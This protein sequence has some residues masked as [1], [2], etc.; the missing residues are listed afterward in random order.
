MFPISYGMKI[1]V[2]SISLDRKLFD[3]KSATRQRTL[4]YGKLADELHVIVFN[5]SSRD[6]FIG[7]EAG[8]DYF[9]IS[10][11]VYVYPTNSKSR[12]FYVFDAL[13][14]AKEIIKNRWQN[15]TK[16]CIIT[17][18]D[19]FE[20][21]WIALRIKKK[22]KLRL[23]VQIHT[24]IFSPFFKKESVLNQI[25]FWM[26]KSVVFGADSIRVV[27]RRVKRALNES[28]AVPKEKIYVLPIYVD[29]EKIRQTPVSVNLHEKYPQ[30]NFICLMA[31]RWTKEKNIPLAINAF[32]KV[33]KEYPGAGLVIVG[34][35][36]EEKK[37]LRKIRWF[38]LTK[39]IVMEGWSDDLISYYKSAD[40]F[41]L[42]SNYEGYGMSVVEAMAAGC[43]V[44]MTGVGLAG[45]LL[46]HGYN[47]L[48]VPPRR[49]EMLAEMILAVLKDPQSAKEL[50]ANA[51]EIIRTLP[52]KEEYLKKYQMIW[53]A[54]FGLYSSADN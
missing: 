18:Q 29:A 53:M 45:D 3:E 34:K 42:T 48:A 26:A 22:F 21:G 25:R 20:S 31:S 51:R 8:V 52:D 5:V 6:G 35:G 13:R 23:L 9:K 4:E 12:W 7:T 40:L 44:I 16:N 39:N 28:W 46:K 14:I 11:N 43:P 17:S 49:P 2:I 54:C 32:K 27:S 19:P 36:P 10:D 38:G 50:V 33:L 30:F 37:I 47:G 24:D 15:D 41:L 1:K